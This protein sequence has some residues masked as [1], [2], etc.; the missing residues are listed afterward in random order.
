MGW[1]WLGIGSNSKL[2]AFRSFSELFEAFRS[3]S[4]LFDAISG[5]SGIARKKRAEIKSATRAQISA[6]RA[7]ITTTERN[8]KICSFASRKHFSNELF[9]AE[10]RCLASIREENG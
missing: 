7:Q 6:T 5:F 10:Y 1:F 8:L 4:E 9:C 3:F 2:L